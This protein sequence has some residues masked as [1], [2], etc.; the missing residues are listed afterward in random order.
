MS[1]YKV[2]RAI[3]RPIVKVLYRVKVI[4]IENEP[5]GSY[6]MCANHSS[7]SD[8]VLCGCILKSPLRFL[9]KKELTKHKLLRVFFGW[10]GIIP[11]DREKPDLSA[12]RTA[13]QACKAGECIGI[14]PQG[15]RIP[16]EDPKP[17]QALS[18]IGLI[19]SQ[20][21]TDVLPVTIYTRAKKPKMFR[22]TYII[23]HKPITPEEYLSEDIP[24][25]EIAQN[26]FTYVC[27][28][29]ENP[30]EALK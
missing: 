19:V 6:L 8:P 5:K 18:G 26:I 2:A 20:C 10:I 25:K 29:F 24:K 1:F 22:R 11:I 27:K 9:A 30:G 13:I 3:A 23:I 21:K 7:L 15:T 28:P 17:E 16:Y 12:I 4:G 14:F